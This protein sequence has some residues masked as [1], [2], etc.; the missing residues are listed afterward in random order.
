MQLPLQDITAQFIARRRTPKIKEQY[1]KIGGKS[2][3]K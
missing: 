1:N 2:P 3:I